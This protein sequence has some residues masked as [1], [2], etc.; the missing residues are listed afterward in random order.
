[1]KGE[2]IVQRNIETALINFTR[3][4]NGAEMYDNSLLESVTIHLR[5]C[6]HSFQSLYYSINTV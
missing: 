5:S 6:P 4:F 2:P 1:M 3:I